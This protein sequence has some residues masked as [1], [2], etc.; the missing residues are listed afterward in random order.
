MRTRCVDGCMAQYLSVLIF[1]ELNNT[2]FVLVAW[3]LA[4]NKTDDPCQCVG[5]VNSNCPSH[6]RCHSICSEMEFIISLL[7][8]MFCASL[9]VQP[10]SSVPG[11]L[12]FVRNPSVRLSV[13][14]YINM[15]QESNSGAELWENWVEAD[16][17]AVFFHKVQTTA[18]TLSTHLYFTGSKTEL[19]E[20][21]S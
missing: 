12:L 3:W 6:D 2:D 15:N 8:L 11:K 9:P 19:Y 13:N 20:V 1:S 5:T 10:V 14:I 18:L 7:P 17:L 4:W 21:H 16:K